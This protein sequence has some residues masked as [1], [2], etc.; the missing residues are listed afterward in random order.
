[1]PFGLNTLC[2]YYICGFFIMYF[3]YCDKP[4]IVFLMHS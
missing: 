4:A 3:N 2:E 1:M